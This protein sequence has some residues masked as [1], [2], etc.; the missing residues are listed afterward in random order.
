MADLPAWGEELL[1][2]S[3]LGHLATADSA[4]TPL[5]VPV[6]Y[7]WD[8]QRLFTA[9]DAKPKQTTR[10]R[11][12]RNIEQNSRVSLCVDHY[13]EDW[14][15]L[16]HVI[17]HGRGR[18]LGTADERSAAVALLQLKYR[19]YVEM[20]LECLDAQVIEIVP[21]RFTAWTSRR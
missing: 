16:C 14:S 13:D 1:R 2:R 10:L 15:V 20:N 6:C 8:G 17:V 19:Q 3:R 9:I 5:V 4:A 11:R 21:E 12:V 7:V 18:L